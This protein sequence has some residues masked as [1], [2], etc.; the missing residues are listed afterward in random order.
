LAPKF[1]TSNNAGVSI[2]PHYLVSISPSQ[3]LIV[4]PIITSKIG[5]IGWLYYGCI[6]RDG[7]FS[8]DSSITNSD[9][10]NKVSSTKEKDIRKII[11]S[12]YRGHI[13]TKMRY[14]MDDFWRCGFD[15]KLVSD[16]YYLKK[17]PFLN[18]PN[19]IL[20]SNIKM[21]E[22]NDRKYTLIKA[23]MFQGDPFYTIPKLLPVLERNFSCTI[24]DGTCDIDMMFVNMS[25]NDSRSAQKMQSNVSWSKTFMLAHG[26]L[27][28]CKGLVSFKMLK[29][30]EKQHSDYN[31][32]LK[33]T[34]QVSATWKYPILIQADSVSTV[35]TPIIGVIVADNKKVSDLFE[36]P[37]CEINYINF[38]D[39]SKS[40]SA[41]NIDAGKRIC[42]GAKVSSHK[43]GRPIF[44][45]TIGRTT[46]LTTVHEKMETSGLNSRNSNMVTSAEVF[47]SDTLTILANG[48]Y[49][50]DTKR[51]LKSEFGA[52]FMNKTFDADIM[53]FNGRQSFYNPFATDVGII[54]ENE[55]IQKY[56]GLML[57]LGWRINRRVKLK[58]AI[59]LGNEK[60]KLIKYNFGLEFKNECL[61]LETAIERTNYNDGD[62]KPETSFRIVLHFK[63]LGF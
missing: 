43:D 4:K 52:R 17:I 63:N 16:R 37:F 9:S 28:D 58:T 45:W 41:Y 54:P 39:G 21:E 1:S 40:M 34:P 23:A 62:L 51:W 25:F 3:E 32:A 49:S 13:F 11:A 24:F 47:L 57:D 59:V 12:G 7:E 10:L 26:H 30:S 42:Y 15:V 46:E 60:N 61:T 31:S 14:E 2:S 29:V 19:R 18:H 56:R 50:T 27:L 36:D 6:F 38:W 8:V 55:K 5:C 35:F 33:I 44:Y 53:A 48:S 20:E 22:F